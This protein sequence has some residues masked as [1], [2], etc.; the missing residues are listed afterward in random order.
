MSFGCGAADAVEQQ[1]APKGLLPRAVCS[2]QRAH[3]A[4]RHR[5]PRP[6]RV[7]QAAAVADTVAGVGA[8]QLV[9]SDGIVLWAAVTWA[10]AAAAAHARAQAHSPLPWLVLL[11]PLPGLPAGSVAVY[12]PTKG[13]L[14]L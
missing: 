7:S 8:I 9:V 6:T 10:P 13:A 5:S 4:G 11:W 1:H 3:A 14:G 2:P 12:Q